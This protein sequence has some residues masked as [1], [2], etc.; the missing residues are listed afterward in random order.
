MKTDNIGIWVEL[1]SYMVT[2]ECSTILYNCRVCV[3][4]NVFTLQQGD[5]TNM[6]VDIIHAQLHNAKEME[7]ARKKL[8][9]G[10]GKA[11]LQVCFFSIL[12]SNIYIALHPVR[13][14]CDIHNGTIRPP[15][16]ANV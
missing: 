8:I 5:V 2:F 16:R 14:C 6:V 3:S 9:E 11:L 10:K 13:N 1:L 15:I 12:D 4:V 7:E